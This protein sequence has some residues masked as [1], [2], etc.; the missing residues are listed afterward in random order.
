MIIDRILDRKGWEEDG[1]YDY[2]DPKEFYN[3]MMGYADMGGEEIAR[4][5]DFGEEEDVRRELCKYITDHNYNPE[6]CKYINSVNWLT[7][8]EP[9]KVNKEPYWVKSH[10]VNPIFKYV[11]RRM[12]LGEPYDYSE[13]AKIVK[14]EAKPGFHGHHPLYY[15]VVT[16]KDEKETKEVLCDMVRRNLSKFVDMDVDKICDF[17]NSVD[18]VPAKKK[19]SKVKI[20]VREGFDAIET[21]FVPCFVDSYEGDWFWDFV[22]GPSLEDCAFSFNLDAW[23][24]LAG[25]ED[26]AIVNRLLQ[27]TDMLS[28]DFAKVSI[29]SFNVSAGG[30]ASSGVNT[31]V[32]KLPDRETLAQMLKD[33]VENVLNIHLEGLTEDVKQAL[34]SDEVVDKLYNDLYKNYNGYKD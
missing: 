15:A 28:E 5:M 10:L 25:I 32:T 20:T 16:Y 11:L 17:V 4:A 6:I 29:K 8:N 2:Y 34:L 26:K 3:D 24:A 22:S 7:A 1:K 13:F 12:E 19:E 21:G 18:W 27:N 33:C 9:P 14:K 23:A 31:Y 30:Y